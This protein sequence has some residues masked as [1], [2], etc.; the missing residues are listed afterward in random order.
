MKRLKKFIRKQWG[1]KVEDINKDFPLI[2]LAEQIA[3]LSENCTKEQVYKMYVGNQTLHLPGL[4]SIMI[5]DEMGWDLR[6]VN[7]RMT[8]RELLED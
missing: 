7:A 8:L 4:I 2:A 3:M 1:I 6:K 5:A